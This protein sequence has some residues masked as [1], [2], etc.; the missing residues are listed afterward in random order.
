MVEIAARR[1]DA[2]WGLSAD[3]HRGG[4]SADDRMRSHDACLLIIVS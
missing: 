3:M 4:M 2:S 1:S